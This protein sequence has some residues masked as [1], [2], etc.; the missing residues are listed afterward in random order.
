[1]KAQREGLDGRYFIALHH[2]P[3]HAEMI[4]GVEHLPPLSP[5]FS[6]STVWC[7]RYVE[8]LRAGQPLTP[9][10]ARVTGIVCRWRTGDTGIV[11]LRVEYLRSWALNAMSEMHRYGHL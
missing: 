1:M 4:G 6:G 2:S 8:C 9:A 7:I 3:E 11:V 10:E 5:G